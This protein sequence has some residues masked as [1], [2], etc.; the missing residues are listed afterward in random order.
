MRTIASRAEALMR[1]KRCVIWSLSIRPN[2]AV[3]KRINQPPPAWMHV[4]APVKRGLFM[5]YT[6]THAG[7]LDRTESSG[8]PSDG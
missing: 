7:T 5:R 8:S 4:S 3:V 1:S 6:S 2:I